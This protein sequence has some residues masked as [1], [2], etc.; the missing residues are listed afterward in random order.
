MQLY[1]YRIVSSYRTRVRGDFGK[2]Y[3]RDGLYYLGLHHR[4]TFKILCYQIL[5][6]IFFSLRTLK[7]WH[8][9]LG[10]ANFQI[11]LFAISFLNK[12]LSNSSFFCV[13]YVKFLNLLDLVIFLLCIVL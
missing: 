11:P 10:Q 13:W 5:V 2:G 4:P 7:L 8:D 12:S 3:E 9:C 1:S 6:L